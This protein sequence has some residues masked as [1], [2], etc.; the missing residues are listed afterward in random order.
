EALQQAGTWRSA[1]SGYQPKLGDIAVYAEPSPFGQ[2][3]N[4]VLAA[5]DGT[6]TTI[7]G[8]EPGG[9]RVSEHRLD[10]SLGLLGY[11]VR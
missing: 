6:L 5:K 11:G 4:F 2:H 10:R 7:G 8:N 9:I 1:S 3:T